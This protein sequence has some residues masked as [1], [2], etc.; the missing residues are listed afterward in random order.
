MKEF[1]YVVTIANYGRADVHWRIEAI[2]E[3]H[4]KE[5]AISLEGCQLEQIIK[6]ENKGEVNNDGK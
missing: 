5:Q 6:V 4:A 2:S 3:E 1:V